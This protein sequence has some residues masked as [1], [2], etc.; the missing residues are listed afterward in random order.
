MQ[1]VKLFVVLVA[2]AAVVSSCGGNRVKSAAIDS[3]R[4][5]IEVADVDALLAGKEE[6]VGKSVAVEAICIH[7]CSHGAR[8]IFLMGSNDS[9]TIRVEAGS[10]GAFDQKCVNSIVAVKGILREERIDEQFLKRWEAQVA[11]NS[12]EK[13]G[14]TESGCDTEK[15]ARGETGNSA[16]ERIADFRARIAAR[17]VAEG[18]EYLSFYY[19]EAQSYEVLE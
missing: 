18:K 7:I 5:A 1:S 11:T 14:D 2:M 19:I 16:A 9:K 15:R 3:T 13:H 6:F 4:A 8:K 12:D 17:K 10:L